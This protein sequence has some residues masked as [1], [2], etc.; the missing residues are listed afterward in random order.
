V[1]SQGRAADQGGALGAEEIA[2]LD[3]PPCAAFGRRGAAEIRPYA[4]PWTAA[5]MLRR[6]TPSVRIFPA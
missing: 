1:S 3:A 4:S 6:D 5:N 2:V